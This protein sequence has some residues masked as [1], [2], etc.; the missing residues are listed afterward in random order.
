MSDPHDS[1]E[2]RLDFH[3][4]IQARKSTYDPGAK[5]EQFVSEFLSACEVRDGVSTSVYEDSDMGR[6]P[7]CSE[8]EERQRRINK[9]LNGTY[10]GIAGQYGVFGKEYM[11][12]LTRCICEKYAALYK[13]ISREDTI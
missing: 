13:T 9:L 6:T 2:Q 7:V 3:S 11:S 12:D 8:T 4:Y 10:R 1:S 5:K